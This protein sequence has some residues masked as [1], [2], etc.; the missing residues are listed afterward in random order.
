MTV[1][2]W[3]WIV[4]VYFPICFTAIIGFLRPKQPRMLASCLLGSLWVAVSLPALELINAHAHWWE[5]APGEITFCAMPV[6]LYL[7]WIAWWGILPQIVLDGLSIP[8]SAALLVGFDTVFMPRMPALTMPR[9]WM[10]GEGAAVAIVLL[11]ALCLARWTLEHKRLHV[12][13]ALQVALAAGLFLFL[14]PEIVF[15]LRPGRGWAPLLAMPAWAKQI[16]AQMI[17]LLALPGVGAVM[18]FA[19]RGGGTPIPYD[20]PPRLVT[21]GIYRYCANPMQMSCALV[22]LF[23]AA[24]LRNVWLLAA[25]MVSISYSAGIAHWDES[26][27][28]EERFDCGWRAYRLEVKNWRPR[29]RPYHA[30]PPARLYVAATCGPCRELRGWI[31]ARGPAG[32]E[33]VD[34]ETLPAGSIMRMRYNPQDGSGDVEGVRAMGRALEHLNLGWALAGAALRIP[35]VWQSVQLVMDASGLGPRELC[36]RENRA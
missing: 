30:G 9:T 25:A 28:L 23:W 4:A 8:W 20:P 1:N 5:Y 29:W 17:L 13:A 34:A 22:M 11:P 2:W 32:M 16:S 10:I 12:R 35:I 19:E 3:N 7:G 27:D 36:A 26:V 24:L 18:E 33:I 31:E 15:A 21:S 6:E 14:V